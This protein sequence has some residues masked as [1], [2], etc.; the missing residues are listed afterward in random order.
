MRELRIANQ[1]G[2]GPARWERSKKRYYSRRVVETRENNS[3]VS[4]CGRAKI[5]DAWNLTCIQFFTDRFC[6]RA[7]YSRYS[8]SNV[9]EMSIPFP[10]PLAEVKTWFERRFNPDPFS[11][12]RASATE[13]KFIDVAFYSRRSLLPTRL[14]D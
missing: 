2:I 5:S 12:S 8:L 6:T 10:R 4:V 9:T 7:R 11:R 14:T 13:D 1:R 3:N